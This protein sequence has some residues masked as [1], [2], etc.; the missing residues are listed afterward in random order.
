M[1]GILKIG[2]LLTNF[3]SS[4]NKILQYLKK[5]ETQFIISLQEETQ[6]V[7]QFQHTECCGLD[8]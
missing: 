8:I 7:I 2:F 1:R 3:L 5:N 4:Q 6:E